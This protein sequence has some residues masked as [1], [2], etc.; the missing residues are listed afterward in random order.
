[1]SALENVH[2]ESPGDWIENLEVQVA[3]VMPLSRK[4]EQ[5]ALKS[6][7]KTQEDRRLYKINSLRSRLGYERADAVVVANINQNYPNNEKNSLFD[8][9]LS[10][11]ASNDPENRDNSINMGGSI[12]SWRLCSTIS[13][14]LMQIGNL[15][16]VADRWSEITNP[17][18][19][20][21]LFSFVSLGQRKLQLVKDDVARIAELSK[22][23]PA[24]WVHLIS[25]FLSNVGIDGKLHDSCRKY[26]TPSDSNQLDDENYKPDQN[27][28]H[29]Q[30]ES[31]KK[32]STAIDRLVQIAESSPF[33]FTPREWC[34]LDIGIRKYLAPGGSIG[35]YNGLKVSPIDRKSSI[36][37][38][39]LIS[40][41]NTDSSI[42]INENIF[43][44]DNWGLEINIKP[45][46]RIDHESRLSRLNSAARA[47]TGSRYMNRIGS[48]K[49]G[50]F[51]PASLSAKT[52]SPGLSS[53]LF[54]K[55]SPILQKSPIQSPNLS[56]NPS[57]FRPSN[58]S[59][60]PNRPY[61]NSNINSSNN[62]NSLNNS[63][64]LGAAAGLGI[65]KIGA[66]GSGVISGFGAVSSMMQARPR[67]QP[68]PTM[69]P[70]NKLG[71]MT[72]KK[73]PLLGNAVP[74][75][76][77]LG[78][79]P[80]WRRNSE[81]TSSQPLLGITPD[82][83]NDS[84]NKHS[85][86]TGPGANTAANLGGL[87]RKSRIQFV[88]I[89]DSAALMQER[90]LAIQELKEK[91]VEKRTS[92]KQIKQKSA[93]RKKSTK[94]AGKNQPKDELENQQI[95]NNISE[96]NEAANLSD[97]VIEVSTSDSVE[98]NSSKKSTPSKP[99][100][101]SK[102][103]PKSNAK[104]KVTTRAGKRTGTRASTKKTLLKSGS[105]SEIEIN[106]DTEKCDNITADA[107]IEADT[108]KT[109]D[110][111][112]SNFIDLSDSSSSKSQS[113][114]GERALLERM[115]EENS[116]KKIKQPMSPKPNVNF[117]ESTK[118]LRKHVA[119]SDILK[120]NDEGSGQEDNLASES[121][122]N[123]DETTEKL[124][125][126]IF[127]NS[128]CVSDFDRQRI[129]R[130]LSG[131]K[132]TQLIDEKNPIDIVLQN[133]EIADPE[134][135]SKTITEQVFF[136]MNVETGEW[137]MLKRRIK[138]SPTA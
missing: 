123:G 120:S 50:G 67:P 68:R 26:T 75:A 115:V 62:A 136:Q 79:L 1:M 41:Q 130:F 73:R 18:K 3:S 77:A 65:S 2:S 132:Q 39:Q 54:H 93:E 34:Y 56:S 63:N 37:N 128:N 27:H 80:V 55:N 58:N 44:N 96:D 14:E 87:H 36:T 30:N 113:A 78:N 116:S 83:H 60:M 95:S 59:F 23:D 53:D 114:V 102:I 137:K 138:Q 106:S 61:Q 110:N 6:S 117:R 127:K 105:T 13:S 107:Q 15:G 97:N 69:Q 17:S 64:S 48:V 66:T 112:P 20:L 129:L 16:L 43:V 90:D 32:L 38:S 88:A 100:T 46:F 119:L 4:N 24:S 98:D 76:H 42:D 9:S 5:L 47:A 35:S 74:G 131:I 91:V 25:S 133:N 134:N 121:S 31:L 85:A 126:A 40:N 81:D 10:D 8:H 118:R 124:I 52:K 19:L 101:R 84:A 70:K 94:T 86:G 89:Q 82:T 29:D 92:T 57:T 72:N 33:R 135:T 49:P 71:L 51:R 12:P 99:K 7:S 21:I 22:S 122:Q 109:I 125:A 104:T 11:P 45:H 108:E 111:N 103:T 28:L